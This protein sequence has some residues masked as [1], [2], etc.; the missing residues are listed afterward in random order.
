MK[1]ED[2]NTFARS[3]NIKTDHFLKA[4]LVETIQAGKVGFTCHA[5]ACGGES[6]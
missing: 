6:E 1:P 5:A 4:G 3:R 2:V